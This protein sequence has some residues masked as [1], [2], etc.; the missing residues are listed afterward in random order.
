MPKNWTKLPQQPEEI[1]PPVSESPS[2]QIKDAG[3]RD[4]ALDTRGLSTLESFVAE[5]P[6]RNLDDLIVSAAVRARINTALARICFHERLYN[7]WNLRSVDPQGARVAINLYGPPGTGKTFCAEGI[8]R[9]L[10]QKILRVNYA[11]IESKY[12][13]ET[14]KNIVAAFQ[15][16]AAAKAVLFFD[17]ADSILGKRLTNITQSADHGVNVSRAVM[18]I[19]LD[20]FEGVVIFATNLARNY[21]GAFV[22]RIAS[23]IQF[24]LPDRDSRVRLWDSL[25]P[26]LVPRHESVT[27]AWLADR[28]EGLSG[29]D[30]L[31]V[32]IA[33]ASRAV[34][35]A[36]SEQVVQRA[37][38]AEEIAF[39][40]A[41]KQNVGE[42]PGTENAGSS[43]IETPINPADLPPDAKQ[44]YE[45]IVSAS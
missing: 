33:A 35:R 5:S 28:S 30:I 2:R 11:E 20:Q 31:N 32:V 36:P 43:V 7:E 44:R 26:Q 18:L 8:A 27:S 34:Q 38:L 3:D 23:H 13:G 41:S 25:F 6:K 19:Q 1:R 45:E 37:D 40:R 22:R 15:A 12:V 4:M 17:E 10:G 24:E 9:H 39:A 16:A 21:D 42:M 29:G 14:P